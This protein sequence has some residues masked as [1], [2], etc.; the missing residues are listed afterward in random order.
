MHIITLIIKF[1]INLINLVIGN[2]V[3]TILKEIFLGSPEM[4]WN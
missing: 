3:I 2:S 4:F 1:I